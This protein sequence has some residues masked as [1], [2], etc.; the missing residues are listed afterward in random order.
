MLNELVIERTGTPFVRTVVRLWRGV[1]RLEIT[2]VLDRTALPPVPREQHSQWHFF[3]FPLSLTANGV[4]LRA[5][6][7]LGFRRV[8]EDSLPGAT[9]DKFAAQRVVDLR[10]GAGYGV[11]LASRQAAVW[12][13]NGPSLSA[14]KPWADRVLMST[15]LSHALEGITKD[16]GLTKFDAPLEPGAPREQVFDYALTANATFDAVAAERFGREFAV[17][18]RAVTLPKPMFPRRTAKFREPSGSFLRVEP[19]GVEWLTLRP[20]TG[21]ENAFLL[22]LRNPR[23][24]EAEAMVTLPIHVVSAQ[25]CDLLG[26]PLSKGELSEINPLRLR[27]GPRGIATAL[28]QVKE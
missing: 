9:V 25:S 13:I 7:P 22:R 11:T 21:L 6:G 24:R 15:A 8:P 23:D 18:L 19:E 2:H 12:Q 20:A 16:Q 4:Q 28:V 27:V 26:R 10:E 17:P 5:E 1:P 14:P 3:G